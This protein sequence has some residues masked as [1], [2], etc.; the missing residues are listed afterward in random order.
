M[1]NEEFGNIVK[2]PSLFGKPEM[3][4]SYNDSDNETLLRNESTK[5]YRYSFEPMKY[6][7]E[8]IRPDVYG[9]EYGSIAS[10]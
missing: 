8:K 4:F 10:E 6:F 5:P 3:I 7:R 9:G 1:I 2:M